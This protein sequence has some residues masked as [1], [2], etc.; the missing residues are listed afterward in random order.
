MCCC[1]CLW[2]W[3]LDYWT[4]LSA[5]EEGC[6]FWSA[7]YFWDGDSDTPSH[8][9]EAAVG[10]DL[11]GGS[12]NRECQ[13]VSMAAWNLLT[14]LNLSFVLYIYSSQNE[15][16]MKNAIHV[17]VYRNDF[18]L[19]VFRPLSGRWFSEID[20]FKVFFFLCDSALRHIHCESFFFLLRECA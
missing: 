8:C 16:I 7:Y 6:A 9:D 5:V 12:V 2:S 18:I 14:T 11:I 20:E 1:C 19:D 13:V 4:F 15:Q 17:V 10:A 3:L